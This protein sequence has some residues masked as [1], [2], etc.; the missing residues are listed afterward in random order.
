[1]NA[2]YIYLLVSLY[3]IFNLNVRG[4]REYLCGRTSGTEQ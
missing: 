3:L 2:Y 4:R 1:M